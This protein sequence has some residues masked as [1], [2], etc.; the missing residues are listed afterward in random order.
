[1]AK[2]YW[3]NNASV[4]SHLSFSQVPS[5]IVIQDKKIKMNTFTSGVVIVWKNF[6][7]SEKHKYTIVLIDL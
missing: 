2:C 6:Y 3:A 1:M 7:L 4:F 5:E